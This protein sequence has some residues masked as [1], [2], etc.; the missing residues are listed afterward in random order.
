[1]MMSFLVLSETKIGLKPYS[2]SVTKVLENGEGGL[3]YTL[4]RLFKTE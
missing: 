3:R 4:C 2:L 1:M